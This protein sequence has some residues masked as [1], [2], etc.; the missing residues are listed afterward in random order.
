MTVAYERVVATLRMFAEQ[1]G[2]VRVTAL[3]EGAVLIECEPHHPVTITR[4]EQVYEVPDDALREVAPLPLAPPRPIPP[5]AI[6]IEPVL[7]EVAAPI[8]AVDSLAAAVK[9]LARAL[10]GRSVAMAEFATATGDALSITA[11]E[12]ESSILVMGDHQFTLGG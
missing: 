6:T 4:G 3:L 2:A 9:D 11:R 1:G 8:G 5:T 7:G 10:G 12:G